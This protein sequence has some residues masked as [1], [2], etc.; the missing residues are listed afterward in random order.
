MTV[1]RLK[2]SAFL[3]IG[4]NPQTFGTFL[5]LVVAL[6]LRGFIR[7]TDKIGRYR[8]CAGSC[9]SMV[10]YAEQLNISRG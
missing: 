4:G 3:N 10:T 9:K 8:C 5:Q 1:Q 2:N 6:I 7:Y